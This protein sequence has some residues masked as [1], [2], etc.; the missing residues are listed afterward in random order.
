MILTPLHSLTA[1]PTRIA[2]FQVNISSVSLKLYYILFYYFTLLY[3]ISLFKTCLATQHLSVPSQR[4]ASLFNTTWCLHQ[5]LTSVCA[6]IHHGAHSIFLHAP[7]SNSPWY[8]NHCIDSL[9][10]YNRMRRFNQRA[11]LCIVNP[12]LKLSNITSSLNAFKCMNPETLSQAPL[13]LCWHYIAMLLPCRNLEL[14][15]YC[16]VMSLDYPPNPPL[17]LSPIS[18][19]SLSQNTRKCTKYVP[20]D[21]TILTAI[22]VI[23]KTSLIKTQFVFL[24]LVSPLILF[25]I[26]SITT[27]TII[28][29]NSI[30]VPI[31]KSQ[32]AFVSLCVRV[33]FA[34]SGTS[35]IRSSPLGPPA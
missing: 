33:L 17:P 9:L 14:Y 13:K 7:C 3:Y 28:I 2:L 24:P 16:K 26:I 18:F 4:Q 35:P 27:I 19:H 29:I 31:P 22:L 10:A 32:F 30:T 8:S 25:I 34:P 12:G 23:T 21:V 1:C 15:W 5:S 11:R 6:L 20:D